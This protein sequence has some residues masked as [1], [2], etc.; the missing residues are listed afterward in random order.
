MIALLLAAT[1]LAITAVGEMDILSALHPADADVFLE[2]GEPGQMF[3]ELPQTPWMRMLRDA[4]MEKLY[5][6]VSTLG[7]DLRASMSAMIPASVL[8]ESSPLR[9][10]QSMSVSLSQLD[11]PGA[12]M[13]VWMGMRMASAE[14]ASAMLGMFTMEGLLLPSG[15]PDDEFK[16]GERVLRLQHYSV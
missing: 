3:A 4:E 14:S 11:Q 9:S 5:G 7:V 16:L 2:M 8:G 12:P 6:L 13:T 10:M 1:P 15:K